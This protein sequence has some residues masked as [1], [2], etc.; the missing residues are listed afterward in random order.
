M[1]LTAFPVCMLADVAVYN[2]TGQA[3]NHFAID[4]V[5][6]QAGIPELG[7]G[8]FAQASVTLSSSL[9][10][11]SQT[12]GPEVLSWWFTVGSYHWSSSDSYSD[13]IFLRANSSGQISEWSI[14][15][16]GWNGSSPTFPNIAA[17]N[18][19]FDVGDWFMVGTSAHWNMASNG[20]AGSWTMQSVPEPSPIGLLLIMCAVAALL[21][22]T[23][24]YDRR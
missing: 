16:R 2:Y 17:H 1:T 22:R 13:N 6:G 4:G 18:R 23:Q 5:S 10:P 7:P 15:A 9:A 3:L 11:N 19:P 21:T 20:V 12:V 8:A 14:E 24:M